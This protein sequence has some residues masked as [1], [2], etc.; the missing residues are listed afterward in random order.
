M[1]WQSLAS[2]EQLR[3]RRGAIGAFFDKVDPV[4]L[5]F[6]PPAHVG[7]APGVGSW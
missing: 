5:A 1:I 7:V 6:Q 2:D 4:R 3:L